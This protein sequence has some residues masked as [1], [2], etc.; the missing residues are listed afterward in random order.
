MA[1]QA[2]GHGEFCAPRHRLAKVSVVVEESSPME[3]DQVPVV[4]EE[5]VPV[6]AE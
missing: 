1:E 2:H 6:E 4:V 5:P 3:A